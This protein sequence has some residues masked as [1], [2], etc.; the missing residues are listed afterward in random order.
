M[1]HTIRS[2]INGLSR[3]LLQQHPT[4]NL[5]QVLKQ[6]RDTNKI[7]FGVGGIYNDIDRDDC[8]IPSAKKKESTLC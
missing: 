7:E 8:S 3:W 5:N 4:K 6:K 2:K 1:L